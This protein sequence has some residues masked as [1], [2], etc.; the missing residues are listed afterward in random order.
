MKEGGGVG[1]D[2]SLGREG[3][4]EG[5]MDVI[6][7]GSMHLTQKCGRNGEKEGGREGERGWRYGLLTCS[8]LSPSSSLLK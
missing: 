6:S 7:T 3:G 4:K 1:D 8:I 5:H 2:M